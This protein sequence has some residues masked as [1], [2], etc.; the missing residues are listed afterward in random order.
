MRAVLVLNYLTL[1][2]H[3]LSRFQFPLGNPTPSNITYQASYPIRMSNTLLTS[4]LFSKY[5]PRGDLFYDDT[6][7]SCDDVK[8]ST[9]SGFRVSGGG[10]P[11]GPPV[12]G[13]YI[14]LPWTCHPTSAAGS[15]SSYALKD[16]PS[17]KLRREKELL[18][19]E[20]GSILFCWLAILK[21]RELCK[22]LPFYVNMCR[23]L[24]PALAI[25][26]GGSA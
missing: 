18:P 14:S 22:H 5:T 9:A 7:A 25:L 15:Q 24:W 8:A 23:Q 26:S 10:F 16:K 4:H 6:V 1:S 2:I 12:V 17:D 19:A 11:V 20:V 21:P 13:T 3:G